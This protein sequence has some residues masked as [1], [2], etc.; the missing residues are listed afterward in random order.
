MAIVYLCFC[1]REGEGREKKFEGEGGDSSLLRAAVE[2]KLN[3]LFSHANA[4]LPGRFRLRYRTKWKF[5][6]RQSVSWNPAD[7]FL[8]LLLSSPTFV[9]MLYDLSL[10]GV[11]TWKNVFT[12][13][14]FRF[15]W[16]RDG[17]E[18]TER[19]KEL[20]DKIARRAW[21][22]SKEE[23]E[24]RGGEDFVSFV[25]FPRLDSSS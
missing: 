12:G 24:D 19:E 8:L 6:D 18:E 1:R 16:T 22:A 7:R 13:R 25:P 3:R 15:K 4:M 20:H 17:Q 5:S 14:P 10:A 9:P 23:E 2:R 21:L 11:H